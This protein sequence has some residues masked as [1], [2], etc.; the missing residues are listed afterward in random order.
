MALAW[1]IVAI[2]IRVPHLA[3]GL[4]EIE[5]EALPARQALDMWNWPDPLNLDPHTA[6]WPSLSFYV[7]LLLQH[8]HFAVGRVLG[9]FTDR[10]DYFV[11]AWLDM[12]RIVLLS[13]A[14]DVALAALIVW[15]GARIARRL[16]GTEGALLVGGLLA[17]SP[18]LVEH[19]QL[20]EPDMLLA[21]FAALAVGRILA[22]TER[23]ERADTLWSGV[24][25]GLGVSSKYTPV[26]LLP[27]VFAAHA[28]HARPGSRLRSLG[29]GWLAVLAAAVSFALTSP[30]VVLHLGV[31]ARDV[32][33]QT[34]HMTGGHFGQHESGLA[35]YVMKVLGP[36][37][38]W[39]G[40]VLGVSGL[41]WAAWAR[42]GPWLA[43]AACVL[44]YFLGL[45][46]L[47]TQFPRYML[48]LLMPIALGL[49]GL[50]VML[51]ER[52][53]APVRWVTAGLALVTFVP[54]AIGVWRYHETV[55]RPSSQT[56]ANRFARQVADEHATILS[57]VLALSLPTAR[58]ARVSPVLLQALTPTQRAKVSAR[59]V[60]EIDVLPMYTIEPER[61]S[62]YYDLRHCLG[63]DYIVTSGSV[64]GR[65][66]A[67]SARFREQTRFY[68]DLDHYGRLVQRFGGTSDV[69]GPE[70]RF[71]Q[72]PSESAAA[73][74]RTRGVLPVDSAR[75]DRSGVDLAEWARFSLGVGQA[76]MARG[77]DAMAE[78]YYRASYQAGIGAGSPAS[79]QQAIADSLARLSARAR[80]P[81]SP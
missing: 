31:L 35:F 36:G 78:R 61:S 19:A 26:L 44:P 25:I 28:I 51:R 81:V 33:T 48:P 77:L 29:A 11:A 75:V 74:L 76:A 59:R 40:F 20:V 46:L 17:L 39:T 15:L 72:I 22:I 38:G 71:Y 65:Y 63:H 37:L 21:V 13:R 4:P 53:K 14:L 67:D 57:E 55:A 56:L 73:L 16:A 18:L 10:N 45:A 32:A 41:A 58:T 6:G 62:F 8:L 60:Y 27:A 64:R 79:R 49:A 34:L 68:A 2:A 3:W 5:E 1:A 52:L 69:R 42:R 24:W 43:L 12:G 23:G 9:I 7:H 70:I 47:R 66:L 54:A 50:V 80:S 30:F